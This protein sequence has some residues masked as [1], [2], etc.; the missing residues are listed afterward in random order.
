MDIKDNEFIIEFCCSDENL[1]L[2]KNR[3]YVENLIKILSQINDNKI[4]INQKFEELS[5]TSFKISASNEI[6]SNQTIHLFIDILNDA[7]QK[8]KKFFEFEN[9]L[10]SNKI[11]IN[12]REPLYYWFFELKE[13]NII[14][15]FYDEKKNRSADFNLM[16]KDL[17]E[18][19]EKIKNENRTLKMENA[20]LKINLDQI[21]RSIAKDPNHFD[22]MQTEFRDAIQKANLLY[23][24]NS[25]LKKEIK[26]LKENREANKKYD[27][28]LE[29]IKENEE[30]PKEN[31]EQK[32]TIELQEKEILKSELQKTKFEN[33]DLQKTNQILRN[34]IQETK[35]NI[36]NLLKDIQ[37]EK[38]ALQTKVENVI[39]E[40]NILKGRNLSLEKENEQIK[41]EYN[42]LRTKYEQRYTSIDQNNK[43]KDQLAL[44]QRQ[45][46]EITYQN[47]KY[48][49]EIAIMQRQNLEITDENNK[50]KDQLAKLQK[51]IL[52]ME[53][54]INN[55]EKENKEI[56]SAI[57]SFQS[58]NQS[59]DNEK[60]SLLEEIQKLCNIIDEKEREKEKLREIYEELNVKYKEIVD[61][62]VEIDNE[63]S[64][65]QYQIEILENNIA[66]LEKQLMISNEIDYYTEFLK[67]MD[68][69]INSNDYSKIYNESLDNKEIFDILNKLCKYPSCKAHRVFV[70]DCRDCFNRNKKEI[71]QDFFDHTI[72]RQNINSDVPVSDEIIRSKTNK[73]NNAS[74]CLESLNFNIEKKTNSQEGENLKVNEV[75]FSENQVAFDKNTRSEENQTEKHENSSSEHVQIHKL[76]FH[77][78]DR[79]SQGSVLQN[80]PD[81]QVSEFDNQIKENKYLDDIFRANEKI[82]N[83]A[84]VNYL[85]K[86][87]KQE[88]NKF[89]EIELQIDP[90]KQFLDMEFKKIM[91]ILVEKDYSLENVAKKTGKDI[92]SII[93][94]LKLKNASSIFFVQGGIN[95]SKKAEF[96]KWVDFEYKKI[97]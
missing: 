51:L 45:N 58:Q 62:N 18:K 2:K 85:K 44:L 34:Q 20:N 11:V 67:K 93:R 57:G 76:D 94:V 40:N 10:I 49:E 6:S 65:L 73:F 13:H 30:I 32:Y 4:Q 28:Q 22:K 64:D 48:I 91:K 69:I 47:N 21:K 72:N 77:N 92:E 23:A 82:N 66:V 60:K 87:L 26:R 86:Q 1:D 88:T 78:K 43:Y 96:K 54:Q 46:S 5:S 7:I 19:I 36:E 68:L 74:R 24:E 52:P 63:N 16:Y 55:L 84:D 50:Y 3:G 71:V 80:T 15:N 31:W 41:S 37:S 8:N 9:D 81:S 75:K 89:R 53:Q 12:R 59:L 38:N 42:N 70:P 56:K 83:A 97:K 90:N 35:A 95:K 33:Q 39:L 29:F 17:K 14:I 79:S 27:N 61:E 25:E